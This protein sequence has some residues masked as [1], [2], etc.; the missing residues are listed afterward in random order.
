VTDPAAF[1]ADHHASLYRYLVRFTGDPDL[2]ADAAQE[3]FARLVERPPPVV[4]RAWLF[5]VAT[6]A[7]LEHTR[8]R[9]RRW[10]LLAARP[11]RAPMADPPRDPHEL[12][13]AS[14][15]RDAVTRALATLSE[16]ERT[17]LLMREEGCAHREIAAA[18]GTTTGSVGTLLARALDRLAAR[19]TPDREPAEARR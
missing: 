11:A 13:E 14:E 12:V 16:K 10:R 3:A 7:A 15:A 4:E 17:A 9:R 18:L 19:L 5:R 6:N 2:A 1:F 8:T